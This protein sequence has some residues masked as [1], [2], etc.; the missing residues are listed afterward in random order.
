[1]W[2][3]RLALRRPYTFVVMALLLLIA[4]V[5]VTRKTPTDILPEVDI[6]VIS[7]VWTYGGLP[8]QQMEQ[9]I[10]QFS[11][12]SLAGNVGDIK[13]LQSDSFDGVSVIRVFLHPGADVAAAMAQVTAASQTIVRRMPPGTIPPIILRYT[14]SSVPILQLAFSSDTLSESEIYDHVNQRVRTMLSV[15]RGTR[16]PLPSGGKQ[17]Q[18]A[19]DLDLAALRAHGLSPSDVNAAITAQNLTLPTGAAKIGEREYRVSLNSSPEAIAALNDVPVRA[20]GPRPVYVR[21]VAHVHDGYAVQTNVARRDGRRSVVLSVMKTGAAS[22]TEVAGR[23]KALVPTIRAS[24]P[25]GLEVELLSDQSTF[26][27][28]AIDGLVVEGLIAAGLT[29]A[30]ILLFLGSWR[31]TLI[32][33]VSIPLSVAAALL[34]LRALGHTINTMTLGG[35]A[36]AVGILVDDAT[37]EVENIHRNLAEG[38]P[39]T[40]A[41]LDGAQQIAVPAFVASLCVSIV[42]VSVVF[43]EGP[44]K[45]IFLPM[46]L[47]VAFSVMASYLLSRTLVPTLVKYLLRGEAHGPGH[48]GGAFARLHRGF[49]ARFERLR[50]RYVGLLGAALARP[51]AALAAFGLAALAAAALAPFVGRDFFPSIDAG[52]VRLHVTAPP[53]TRLEE[54]ERWFSRVEDKIREIVP[55]GD[56]ESILDFIGM[57]G[58]YNLSITDSSNVSSADGE[59]LVTLARGRSRSTQDTVRA[60]RDALPGEFPEL[61]FYFQPAD[62]VTQILNFGLPSPIDVQVSGARRDATLAAARELEAGLRAVPG[63][64][65]VHLH[66]VVAAPRLHVEVD[67]LRASEV[68]LT[69]RD[70]ASNLLLTVSSSSQVNPTFWTEASTGNA[71]PVALQVPEYRVDSLDALKALSLPAAGAAGGQK[72]LVD[73]AGIRRLTT[74]VFVTHANVQ[75]TYNVRAD[76]Q[77]A[78]LGRVAAGLDALVAKARAKLPPGATI[79]VR[80]QAESMREGFAGLGVGLAFAALLVYAL[81]VVNFQSWKLPFIILMALPGAGVGIVFALFATDTTF[82]IP[83]LMGAVMSVGVATANSI[84]VVTFANE[85]RL[86]GAGALEAALE[87]GAVRLRPVLMTAL[88]MLIGML[89]MSLGLGEGGEQNAALGRAVIGG[90]LG[91]T[92]AT[93]VLVPVV[94]SLLAA[95]WRAPERDPHLEGPAGPDATPLPHPAPAARPAEAQ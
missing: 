58:G 55:A 53:G 65:D 52:Q 35:L 71:Y 11:E 3:V 37:V 91:A 95:R 20:G 5:Y 83:S 81:M 62:I 93:L 23:V 6:P 34:C 16:F 15:V 87:A 41:I 40:R 30:M 78:D 36:L 86:A 92:V 4:G 94:Y 17:R 67:R 19:V 29:A 73:L 59:V 51:R 63:A 14:A 64:V 72:L 82:S 56:R 46:G 25:P 54:T 90:L 1:M 47:A 38:K 79:T 68:G 61:G 66:Q 45:Y 44:A 32:V 7:V 10:T 39:L 28:R 60:L 12:Y 75:P 84:L 48:G 49:D 31:S 76:A 50:G 74:P 42:F 9:Q 88:A 69:E 57:P 13:A 70:V 2:I 18:I 80:G 85:R 89:P 26:V 77:D 24:A 27:T 33:A 8:A 21:D 43:L 22:T